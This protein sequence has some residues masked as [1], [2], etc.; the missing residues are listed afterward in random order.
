MHLKFTWKNLKLQARF[1]L[2]PPN[3]SKIFLDTRYTKIHD[4]RG[5]VC[6]RRWQAER[7]RKEN[8]TGQPFT[9]SSTSEQTDKKNVQPENT[10]LQIKLYIQLQF[11]LSLFIFFILTHETKQSEN[12][13]VDR[14]FFFSSIS[15]FRTTS[16]KSLSIPLYLDLRDDNQSYATT[17][18]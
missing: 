2:P 4:K 7:T 9:V 15:Y 12:F 1:F 14:R 13:C 8:F 17:R 10:Q 5:N 11:P 16:I 18:L 6:S 3:Y